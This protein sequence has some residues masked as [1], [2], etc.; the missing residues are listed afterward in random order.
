M[1]IVIWLRNTLHRIPHLDFSFHAVDNVFVSDFH[2]VYSISLVLLA[3][4]A[5]AIGALFLLC[6][7]IVWIASCCT[8]KTSSNYSRRSVRR[9][10]IS[11]FLLN[12]I[13]FVLLAG[14]LFGND[15]LNRA[16]GTKVT[17]Q[18]KEL[19]SNLHVAN[20]KVTFLWSEEF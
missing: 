18:L 12:V 5:L 19:N 13:C 6:L 16:I 9:L 1:N 17:P 8:S 7:V 11:L 10:T 15:Y 2:D 20:D 14:C 4:C 3:I